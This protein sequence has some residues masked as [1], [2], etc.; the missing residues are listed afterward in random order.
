M[1]EIKAGSSVSHK[2]TKET[3]FVLGVNR[4]KNQVCVAGWPPTIAK[5]S[6]CELAN[7]GNGINQQEKE[8]RDKEFGMD[9][10]E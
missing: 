9:W 8:Y 4:Q 2:P 5:L 6:D 1:N 3:W 10:E 7:I